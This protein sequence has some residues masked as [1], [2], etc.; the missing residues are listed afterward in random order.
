MASRVL[1]IPTLTET[2]SPWGENP[3]HRRACGLGELA[4][5]ARFWQSGSEGVRSSLATMLGRV[6]PHGSPCG[7][8]LTFRCLGDHTALFPKN[9]AVLCHSSPTKQ[10]TMKILQKLKSESGAIGWALLWLIG[11][12]VPLL[13]IFFVL[14][15]CT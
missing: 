1:F 7:G 8:K 4:F 10:K 14:R 5:D 6:L 13:L 11:V 2:V 3:P 15:G 9:H 12:P